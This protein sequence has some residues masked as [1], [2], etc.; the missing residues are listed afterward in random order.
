MED[1]REEEDPEDQA[2]H[3]GGRLTADPGLARS[4]VQHIEPDHACSTGS[5]LY[6]EL[7]RARCVTCCA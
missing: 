1:Q 6:D 3:D 5:M 2:N 4:I 7:C